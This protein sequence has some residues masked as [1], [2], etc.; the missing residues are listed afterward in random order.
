M[1]AEPNP[2]VVDFNFQQAPDIS[3]SMPP[4]PKNVFDL[5]LDDPSLPLGEEMVNDLSHV[6]GSQP[7][8]MDQDNMV[9]TRTAGQKKARKSDDGSPYRAMPWLARYMA[10]ERERCI[11]HNVAPPEQTFFA[12]YIEKELQGLGAKHAKTSTL[13]HVLIAS[14]Y[15]I[16][17]LRELVISYRSK[18]SSRFW[19]VEPTVSPQV[20][21]EIISN[22]DCNITA[23]G[24]LRR[25]HILR[26][27]EDSVPSDS[28]VLTNFINSSPNHLQATKRP[29]NP[30][31]NAKADVTSVMTKE[32]Y[33]GL[34]PSSPQYKARH[35]EVSRLQILGRRFH[36]LVARFHQGILGLIPPPG[37]P[38]RAIDIDISDCMYVLSRLTCSQTPTS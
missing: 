38:T 13:I 9:I 35:R 2:E 5:F 16:A 37:G 27:F 8:F 4:C 19:Q 26:L 32:I 33:H 6:V 7:D 14:P 29:G 10:E 25:Y 23:Y 30:G 34:D 28:R 22:L 17:S 12:E 20:R 11:L 3:I 15:A 36:A 31:N 18:G 1:P 21:F 24:I